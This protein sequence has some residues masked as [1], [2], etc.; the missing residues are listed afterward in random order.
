MRDCLAR[1]LIGFRFGVT[2]SR[3]LP[4]TDHGQEDRIIGEPKHFAGY[5][6]ALGGR[7]DDEVN[8]SDGELWNTIFTPSRGVHR[9]LPR[10]HGQNRQNTGTRNTA[11]TRNRTSKGSPSFQ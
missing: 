3:R 1:A 7:D 8:L 6:A 4:G 11:T 9:S 5:G 2:A 10:G